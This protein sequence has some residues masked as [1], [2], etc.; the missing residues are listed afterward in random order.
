[1]PL[2]ANEAVQRIRCGRLTLGFGPH[3][4]DLHFYRGRGRRFFGSVLSVL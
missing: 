4:F 1:M 3:G 2:L